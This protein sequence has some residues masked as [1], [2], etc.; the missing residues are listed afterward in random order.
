MRRPDLIALSAILGATLLALLYMGRGTIPLF[1]D[2]VFWTPPS[3]YAPDDLLQ[4]YN[5]HAA[6]LTRFFVSVS[7]DLGGSDSY[8]L[9]RLWAY[10]MHL[11]TLAALYFVAVPY[12]GRRLAL[13]VIVPLTLMG[14]AWLHMVMPFSTIFQGPGVLGLLLA[15][16]ALQL[17][18]RRGDVVACLVLLAAVFTATA[19]LAAIAGVIVWLL[20][21]PMQLRRLWVAAV[22][23]VLWLLWYVTYKPDEGYEIS[24]LDDIS[25]VPTFVAEGLSN[26]IRTFGYLPA[27]WSSALAAG[28]VVLVVIVAARPAGMDRNLAAALAA[29]VAF[30]GIIAVGRGPELRPDQ[31]RYLYPDAVHVIVI[32]VIA[33]GLAGVRSNRR[34]TLI[35]VVLGL[36][37]FVP[38]F[39]QLRNTMQDERNESVLSRAAISA[40]DFS[41]VEGLDPAFNPIF[42]TRS[43]G[44]FTLERYG[45]A[46]ADGRS[47]GFTEAE[48]AGKSE[49]VRRTTDNAL[50]A[51]RGIGVKDAAAPAGCRPLAASAPLEVPPGTTV[52]V[53]NRG[54]DGATV[55]VR[56]FADQAAD[57]GV[58]P[59]RGTG[60]VE[61]PADRAKRPWTVTL[62]GNGPLTACSG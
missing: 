27:D 24:F 6:V 60:R 14:L 49:S 61:L 62:A 53:V 56:R 17:G 19:G 45:R 32:A 9:H 20:W 1:D 13:I 22:P 26:G 50:R 10:A 12:V 55:R 58:V 54:V 59:G 42:D 2:W 25:L 48:L 18:T 29:A 36:A 31:L 46:L 40:V 43:D 3:T 38:S 30:W 35:A 7:T 34:T 8:L 51:A 39:N 57:V 5:G 11:A 41:G 28:L 47:I 44:E 16:L 52:Y 23:A 4:H 33:A 37:F 15:M 21:S